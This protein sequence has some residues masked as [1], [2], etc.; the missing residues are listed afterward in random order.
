[1]QK[2]VGIGGL[3]FFLAVVDGMFRIMDVIA[4]KNTL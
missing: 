1:M 3:Y 4:H 2:V